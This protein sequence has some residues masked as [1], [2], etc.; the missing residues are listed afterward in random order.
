[1]NLKVDGLKALE[2]IDWNIEP[3]K[4]LTYILI[5]E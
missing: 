2:E 4:W 5:S 1:M 3:F